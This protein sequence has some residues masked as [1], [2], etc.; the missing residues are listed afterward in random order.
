MDKLEYVKFLSIKENESATSDHN[1]KIFNFIFEIEF[2]DGSGH[3]L[4]DGK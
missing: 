2:K 4:T 3:G 1:Q